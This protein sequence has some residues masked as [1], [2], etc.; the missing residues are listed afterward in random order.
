MKNITGP[1]KQWMSCVHSCLFVGEWLCFM[2]T[3][4]PASWCVVLCGCVGESDELFP[5][6]V[7]ES[8]HGIREIE[9]KQASNFNPCMK[10]CEDKAWVFRSEVLAFSP[11]G[12][13]LPDARTW[14][15]LARMKT[16][17]YWIVSRFP[18]RPG[19][20]GLQSSCLAV[21]VWYLSKLARG[22]CSRRSQP[23]TE[24]VH[25]EILHWKVPLWLDREG[26]PMP[27]VFWQLLWVFTLLI[28][29][30]QF[31]SFCH[32]HLKQS[33][34]TRSS[35]F[36]PLG[37]RYVSQDTKLNVGMQS[38]VMYMGLSHENMQTGFVVIA[39]RKLISVLSFHNNRLQR[40]CSYLLW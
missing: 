16:R 22:L 11:A 5:V 32:R 18:V 19:P 38:Q 25:M 7:Q 39:T 4:K 15:I 34:F 27:A 10:D 21:A 12:S 37:L 1:I 36:Q 31:N 6:V 23:R 24:K 17:L 26:M 9:E 8:D 13:S 33:D 28:T 14:R 2:H 40:R 29:T 35:V 3:R 30:V 20:L